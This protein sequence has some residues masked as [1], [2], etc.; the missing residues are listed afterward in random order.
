MPQR[1][2]TIMYVDNSN[3]FRSLQAAGWRIDAK[4]LS[5]K[6]EER[7]DIWQT[8]F[9]AAVNDP[10]RY[11]QTNFYRILKEE[12]HWETYIFPEVNYFLR[13]SNLRTADQG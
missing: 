5:S 7:G 9:F 13:D 1:G 4:K 3:V 2:R 12:L 11:Q 8:H 10:P 6:M